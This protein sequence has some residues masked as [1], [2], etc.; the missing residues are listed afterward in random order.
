MVWE[1]GK[2]LSA[3]RDLLRESTDPEY[4]A[5]LER[6]T[7][8][9]GIVKTLFGSGM[10]L[11]DIFNQF[12]LLTEEYG[13]EKIKT[14]GDAY[15][16]IGGAPALSGDHTLRMIRFAQDINAAMAFGAILSIPPAAWSRTVSRD[17][18]M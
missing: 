4:N 2:W 9:Y 13:L 14:I 5:Y 15:M 3:T 16:V 1:P 12:D 17:V 18:F 8:T 10:V 11:N 7:F 6:N